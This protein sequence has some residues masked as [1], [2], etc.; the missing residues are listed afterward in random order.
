[1]IK[2]TEIQKNLEN[3]TRRILNALR[4]GERLSKRDIDR[5]YN[6]LNG[7]DLVFKARQRGITI[8]TEMVNGKA[9]RYAV[10]FIES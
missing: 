4:R 5:K 1:M 2:E 3:K 6:Y 7:G 8:K 10:Y 9:S